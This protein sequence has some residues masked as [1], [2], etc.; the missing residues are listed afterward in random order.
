MHAEGGYTLFPI[1]LPHSC[2]DGMQFSASPTRLG[3]SSNPTCQAVQPTGEAASEGAG[4]GRDARLGST[5]VGI[6]RGPEY[7]CELDH[8]LLICGLVT[9]RSLTATD[10]HVHAANT[11]GEG[12]INLVS[13]FRRVCG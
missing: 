4:R 13:M 5:R 12:V 9:T 3:P 6:Q 8:R 7:L 2:R 11:V 10:A 1:T